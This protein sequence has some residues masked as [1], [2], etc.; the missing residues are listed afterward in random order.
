[1]ATVQRDYAVVEM[2]WDEGV[3]TTLVFA[4]RY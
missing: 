3:V 2:T 1:M 4:Y